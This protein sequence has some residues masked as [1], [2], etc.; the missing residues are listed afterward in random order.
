M[1]EEIGKKF[2]QQVEHVEFTE[3]RVVAFGSGAP[4]IGE[5]MYGGVYSH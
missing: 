5:R 3:P 2:E 1:L 4:V